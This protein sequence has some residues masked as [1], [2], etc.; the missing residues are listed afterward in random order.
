VSVQDLKPNSQDISALYLGN[1]YQLLA[2]PNISRASILA[3]PVQPP[4]FT[5]SK[6]AIWVNSLWFLSLVVSLTCALL[7]TLLQQW[8]RRYVTITQPPRYSPHKRAPIRAFF[9]NGAEKFHLPWS[10]EALPT[11]LH[12]SLFLFFIGLAIYLFNINHTVFSVVVWWVGLA[13]GVYACITLMPIFWHYSPYYAP[14]S[15]SAWFL[16]TGIPYAVSKIVWFLRNHGFRFI[17]YPPWYIYEQRFYEGMTKTIQETGSRLSAEINSRILTWTI[18]ALDEDKELEQFFEAIPAF[19]SS[20]FVDEFQLVFDKLDL[21]LA[22]A[23]VKFL[24][25]TLTSSLVSEEDKKRRVMICVKAINTVHLPRSSMDILESIFGFG[26]D[27]V[28]GSLEIVQSLRSSG[29]RDPGLCNRGIIAGV[30]ASVPKSE[31]DDWWI[32]LA[33]DQLDASEEVVRYYLAH[34]DSVLLANLIHITRL[35]LRS[36]LEDIAW[37]IMDMGS[38]LERLSKLDIRNT[39]PALQHDFCILWNEITREARNHG[40]FVCRY[41]LQ[42]IRHLYIA[43]HQGTDAAPTAFDASTNEYDLVFHDPSSYPLCNIPGHRSDISTSEKTY[44]L[45]ITST[46]PNPPDAVLSTISPSSVPDVSSFPASTVDHGRV[47]FAGESSLHDVVDATPTTESPRRPPPVNFEIS[48]PAAT[49][50]DLIRQ[51]PT[52]TAPTTGISPTSNTELDPHPAP[53]VSIYVP[54]PCSSSQFSNIPDPQTNAGLGV[55]PNIPLSS[56]SGPVASDTPLPLP[57]LFTTS[58]SLTPPQG[59]SFSH[60]DTAPNSS[61]G[62]FNNDYNPRAQTSTNV[63]FPERSHDSAMSVPDKGTDVPQLPRLHIFPD[64]VSSSEG[65]DRPPSRHAVSGDAP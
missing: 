27:L 9:A 25:N 64:T 62:T 3:N 55:V 12:L 59:T 60:T 50:L 8:A 29:D 6:S 63:E 26:L 43:L 16:Y 45:T 21:T 41:V 11:L 57:S 61:D 35:L 36:C 15:S 18:Q 40:L 37:M 39:L 23:F 34:G 20:K 14:L 53:A 44:P 2:D 54:H 46:P 65:I 24:S 19:C 38:I 52:A 30:I 47:H 33:K 49:S 58:I 5:P 17:P 13:G 28:L 1:I 56:Y 32:E 48:R 42:P 4:P 51:G 22:P 10:V 31:R 7:A